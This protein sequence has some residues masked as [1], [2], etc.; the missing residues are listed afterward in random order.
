MNRPIFLIAWLMCINCTQQ[1]PFQDRPYPKVETYEVKYSGQ[2]ATLTATFFGEINYK[3]EDVT[4]YG[5]AWKREGNFNE[6]NLTG[7]R[8]VS[9]M[10]QAPP[11]TKFSYLIPVAYP[12]SSGTLYWKV[13]A[14]VKSKNYTYYGSPKF[15]C[16]PK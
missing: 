1:T 6:T 3:I 15:F 13:W 14:Y 7:A 12:T 5:F 2:D 10:A 4:D 11:S 8:S 16:C 9:L